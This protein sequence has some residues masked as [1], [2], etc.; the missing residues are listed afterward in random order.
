[1]T[2]LLTSKLIHNLRETQ[3]ALSSTLLGVVICNIGLFSGL[4]L[5]LLYDFHP[6]PILEFALWTI[7]AIGGALLLLSLILLK[8]MVRQDKQSL[9]ERSR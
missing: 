5:L 1:M 7:L 8:M 2:D 3:A 9:S 6:G 4:A